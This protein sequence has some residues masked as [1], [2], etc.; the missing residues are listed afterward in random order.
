MCS[1]FACANTGARCAA[2]MPARP[3]AAIPA[4]VAFRTTGAAAYAAQHHCPSR[5]ATDKLREMPNTIASLPSGI[6]PMQYAF[7]DAGGALDLGAFRLQIDACLRAGVQGIA[8]LGL[9]TEVAKLAREE[10]SALLGAAADAIGGRAPLSVTVFGQTPD[11]QIGFVREAERAGAASVVLQPP[12]APGMQE[13]E[14][15][16]F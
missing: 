5:S 1:V 11:E 16:R 14:L 6:V 12:R 4:P 7:F 10:R 9:A 15:L 8:I 2:R 13:A 3:V